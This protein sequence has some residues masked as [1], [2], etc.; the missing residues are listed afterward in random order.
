[1]YYS[2]IGGIKAVWRHVYLLILWYIVY[3]NHSLFIQKFN[4]IRI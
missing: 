2:F 3:T 4:A 1:M